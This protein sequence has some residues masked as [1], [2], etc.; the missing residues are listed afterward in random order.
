MKYEESPTT[1]LKATLM[2]EVKNEILAFLNAHGGTIYVGVNNDGSLSEPLSQKGRDEMDSRLG[3]WLREAFFPIPSQF[4]RHD[5][6]DDGVLVISIEEGNNKPYFLREK[7]PKPSGVYIREGRST[8]KANEDEILGMIMSS[9]DYRFE[10]DLS[11]RQ[12]L[13]FSFFETEMKEKG[14]P[15]DHRALITLGVRRPNG[16]YT[17]LGLLLSDQSP[18]QVKV[19][20]YDDKLNFRI[21]R[22]FSGSLLRVLRDVQDMCE[23]L[24]DVSAVID[25]SS[26]ERK[27]TISYPGASL[28]EMVLNAFCHANYYV[29]SNIKIEFF[30]NECRVTSP[31]GIYHATLEDLLDGIQ[32]YRNPRLV[33]V[34][35]KL[36]LIEN[37]GTGIPRTLEAYAPFGEKPLFKPSDNF[38]IVHL[39]NL[40]SPQRKQSN[41]DVLNDQI[42]DRLNDVCLGILRF[43][44]N[45]PGSRIDE[46][47]SGIEGQFG[48]Q[49][50]DAIYNQI[51]RYLRDYLEFR[52]PK[53]SGGYHLK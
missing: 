41:A 17:N 27:E 5:F 35:D 22:T 1:E 47:A 13:T 6:N 12:D 25:G 18:I 45:H 53:K 16:E 3:N 40:N 26:F 49:T 37:F 34:F 44:K 8:R 20:E 19:A 43:V 15:L 24:N 36:G 48:S 39:P 29:R 28:R 21:K 2:D 33:N 32:T 30:P 51:K 9:K 31:G 14:I 50:A 42:N 23:R 7:G 52:G 46:I 38:F 4:V 11:E 10:D